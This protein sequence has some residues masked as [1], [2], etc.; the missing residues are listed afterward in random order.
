MDQTGGRPKGARR[1][2]SARFVKAH[3]R[4]IDFLVGAEV[5]QRH[6][7]SPGRV[8]LGAGTEIPGHNKPAR[9]VC[10]RG[11]SAF[12]TAEFH[13]FTLNAQ[14]AVYCATAQVTRDSMR[15]AQ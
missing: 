14:T 4:A 5:E 2:G 10:V 13:L 12:K 9:I 1:S 6:R 3:Q 7:A 11:T 8:P 15:N